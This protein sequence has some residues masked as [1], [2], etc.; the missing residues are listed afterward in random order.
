M[1]LGS[2][3]A[4][5]R[6]PE[7]EPAFVPYDPVDLGEGRLLRPAEVEKRI[8]EVA[9]SVRDCLVASARLRGR[10]QTDVLLALE[11][12]ADPD[13]DHE[14]AVLSALSA[15]EAATVRRVLVLGADRDL[16]A[17]QLERRRTET[18]LHQV[19]EIAGAR[20]PGVGSAV[21]P[22]PVPVERVA[23]EFA[24]DGEGVAKLTWGQHE[25]WQS[26]TRQ[27][28]WLPLGGWRPVDPGT[29]VEAIADELAYLHSRFPS[30]RT[31]LRF[32]EEGRL[33]QELSSSGTTYLDVF[34]ADPDG[35][36]EAAD[37]LATAISDHYQHLPYD[38]RV[39]WPV[40][41]GVVRQGGEAVRLAVAMHHLALDG[42]GAETMLRD[43]ATRS[44]EKPSG[45]QQLE[46]TE[47]Q[48]SAA[49]RRHSDRAM[50]HFGDILRVMPTPTFP[51]SGD[52]RRP[53]FWS[54]E[55]YS[56]A[57][58]PALAAIRERT[59]A[60]PTRI[61]FAVY[62]IALAHVTGVHPALFRPVI[63]NRFRHQ[64]ADVVC[65]A[66]QAGIVLLDVAD[67]TVE[68]VIERAGPAAMN[69]LKH[70]YFDPEQLN[71]LVESTGRDRG[72]ELD[73]A[74][75]LNDRRSM[76]SAVPAPETAVTAEEFAKVRAASRFT[77]IQR[78]NDPVE[79][80]FLHV[81]DGP[82]AVTL[83][84]EADTHGMSPA[85]IESL[86]R[87]IEEVAVQ[88]ALQPQLSTRIS[89]H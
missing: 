62:G 34:D 1:H 21:D 41:M 47:W 82:D 32:D 69:A 73:I 25:I 48:T 76:D 77:W 64:L 50:R 75:F 3:L 11:T 70:S 6:T 31:L 54:A 4:R 33:R 9:P 78:R 17:D 45:L 7:S 27:G 65:H 5:G 55:Y 87:E 51:P 20:L 10:V 83:T 56:P 46:Q 61:L 68:D 24:G 72:A 2:H 60:D 28:N 18:W 81:D 14:A 12:G 42:G 13:D 52:P 67:G 23:V 37:A 15:A 89:A 22:V 58:R 39:E 86:V 35:G 66:A 30:M 59:G 79:R 29:P 57:L 43:V 88:A 71:E 8:L 19:A 44:R 85:Q 40:R 84:V 74:S 53:R 49:G 63:G 16:P 26:M 80:L 36:P 38:L